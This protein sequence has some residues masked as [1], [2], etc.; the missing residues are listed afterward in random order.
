MTQGFSFLNFISY[1]PYRYDFA[2]ACAREDMRNTESVVNNDH[3]SDTLDMF[4]V[5]Y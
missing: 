4:L 3:L 2:S 5:K 1:Q